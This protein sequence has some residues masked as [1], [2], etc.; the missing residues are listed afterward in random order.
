MHS[1]LR[2]NSRIDKWWWIINFKYLLSSYYILSFSAEHSSLDISLPRI[3]GSL[4]ISLSMKKSQPIVILFV[5]RWIW[6]LL[7]NAT[8]GLRRVN[9]NWSRFCR[10]CLDSVIQ[11]QAVSVNLN[12]VATFSH[13][14]YFIEGRVTAGCCCCCSSEHRRRSEYSLHGDGNSF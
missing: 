6:S 1:P 7:R 12:F 11:L 8:N 3:K 4:G 10:T 9:I 13:D 2:F 14:K 5:S